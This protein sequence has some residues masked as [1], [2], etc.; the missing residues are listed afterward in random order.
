MPT[1]PNRAV[2]RQPRILVDGLD[3][4]GKTTLVDTLLEQLGAA[5]VPAIRH[6]GMLAPHHPLAKALEHLPLEHQYRSSGITAAYLLAFALD[7]ALERF[8]PP[9]RGNAVLVQEG[10][11]D[12]TIAVGLAGGPFLPA[13]LSLWAAPHFPVF[14][15]AVYLHAPV[16]VR[17]DR[18]RRRAQPDAGDQ[19]SVDDEGFADR[20]TSA[21][22]HFLGRRHRKLLV[23]DSSQCRP[24]EMARQVLEAAALP[25]TVPS[26]PA[27]SAC[28]PPSP[29]R[30]NSS[31]PPRP[32]R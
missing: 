27:D 22:L 23:F 6:R 31:T 21:M 26:P 32:S 15:V 28:S 8:D 12:R 17:R 18:L 13:A 19:H 30:A 20:F 9:H 14:D 16:A 5:E 7:A 11:V 1:P 3:M 29:D 25:T 2:S 4:S 24:E 10:Y